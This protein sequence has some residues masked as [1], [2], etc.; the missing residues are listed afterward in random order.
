MPAIQPA[1]LK[2]QVSDLAEKYN[3]PLLFVRELHA[4]LHLYTDHTHR[5][6]Q[7]GEPSLLM[8]AYKAPPPV[9]RQVW[10]AL[11]PIIKQHPTVVLPLC[12]ALWAESNY[13][14]QLL[15]SRLLGQLPVNPPDPVVERLQSWIGKGIEKRLLDGVLMYGLARLQQ[16]A[17]DQ[18]QELISAWLSSSNL[19][20]QRAGLR[21]LLPMIN[22]S[23]SENL[24]VI[25]RLLTPYLRVAPSRLRPDIHIVLTT[26]A[27]YSPAETAFLLRQNL[28]APN[29]P[30]TPWIIRQVLDEFP[31]ETRIGLRNAMKGIS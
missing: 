17:P 15:A 21:A 24:P 22:R 16:D 25:F 30:D 26:L 12:D 19:H 27:Q 2:Q 28:S 7:S 18:L 11:T 10:Y 31:E 20:F 23:G 5:S 29:N 6:G 1:R 13:D 9:M 8:K 4:L 3:Q 14:M